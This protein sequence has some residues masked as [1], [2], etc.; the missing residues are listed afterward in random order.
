MADDKRDPDTAQDLAAAAKRRRPAP[1]I[2]LK[3]T[4]VASEPVTTTQPADSPQENPA[5]AAPAETA[6][7]SVT[8]ASEGESAAPTDPAPSASKEA[9]RWGRPAWRLSAASAP[10]GDGETAPGL[11][12]RIINRLG[13]RA[14]TAAAISAAVTLCAAVALW[15]VAGPSPNDERAD[16]LAARMTVLEM[17]LGDVA[18]K[19][20]QEP[21][22]AALA[23][24][25]SRVGK[26]EQSAG[27]LAALDG[28][29]TKL[30]QGAGAAAALDARIARLEKA[31]PPQAGAA[32][33]NQALTDRVTALETALREAKSRADAAFDAAQK[34]TAPSAVVA[35]DRRDID[36]LTTRVAAL[37]QAIKGADERI[38]RA[39]ATGTDK[40]GR[41]AF[42]ALVLRT[43]A[44]R[45][46]PFVTE[47]PAIRPRVSDAAPIAALEP[48]AATGVPRAAKLAREL[49]QL[50]GPMLNAAGSAPRESGIIDR[51]QQGAERL[52]RIRPI[53]ETPGDDPATVISRAE[54]KAANG[55]LAGALADLARLPDTV[56]APAK[57][58]MKKAETQAAA[59]AAARRL[60]DMAVG[61]LAKP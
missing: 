61:G 19:P 41:L 42:V 36:A 9:P 8:N 26:I 59:L 57:D 28:R 13:F 44:E 54:V 23:D 17:K 32:P 22:P 2:D 58:W 31:P 11:R 7:P 47:L 30:E 43:A 20:S 38:A 39:A 40:A 24:L 33:D 37:E 45:G 52:V 4:E 14:L 53:N 6:A 46:D 27:G 60:A 25:A 55:D 56:R 51:L 29:I 48:F 18:R 12:A 15:L 34:N 49:S 35:A 10:A 1:T 50:A 3:A 21:G 5:S 16:A